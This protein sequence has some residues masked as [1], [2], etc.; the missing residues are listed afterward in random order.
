[1]RANKLSKLRP[2]PGAAWPFTGFTLIE[3]LVVIAI[4]AILAA[5]LLP[6]LAQAKLKALRVQCMSNQHQLMLAWI[7]YADD[8]Q[9]NL[10]PNNSISVSQFN[11]PG[12]DGRA[13]NMSWG[14]VPMNTEGWLLV[15]NGDGLLGRYVSQQY[16]IFQCPGDNYPEHNGFIRARS[17]SMN[18]MMNGYDGAQYLN[19][20]VRGQSG[21][22]R[23]GGNVAGVSY[24]LYTTT[25]SIIAPRPA[26][27]WVFIDEHG[28]SINDGFFCV[29]VQGNLPSGG[30]NYAGGGW[31]DIPASYHGASG[32]LSYADGH[33]ESHVWADPYVRNHAVIP[34]GNSIVGHSANGY[35]DLYWLQQRTT[36]TY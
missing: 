35:P 22:P 12:W 8:N 18:G 1:M 5:L 32:V 21:G 15:T 30:Y 20:V 17:I 9:G 13:N 34:Y 23:G 7:M 36:A 33:A 14:T 28:N 10:V 24:R 3:L 25:G 16:R 26:M 31:V 2:I 6:A 11:T 27:A 29:Q 4:I 19:G